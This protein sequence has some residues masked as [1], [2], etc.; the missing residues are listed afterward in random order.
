[1]NGLRSFAP[2]QL[3]HGQPHSS[4]VVH[5]S[6][7]P[8]ALSAIQISPG[9]PVHAVPRASALEPTQASAPPRAAHAACAPS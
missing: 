8:P 2:A 6:Y 9:S 5:V 3:M 1:M 7:E 4:L